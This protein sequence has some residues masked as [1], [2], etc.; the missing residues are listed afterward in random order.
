MSFAGKYF[1]Q[2]FRVIMGTIVV[3]ILANIYEKT[4]KNIKEKCKWIKKMY[5]QCY[6]NDS[7]IMVL[8]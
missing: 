3:P 1:Q 7:L 5:G 2:I 6:L 8:E 4:G